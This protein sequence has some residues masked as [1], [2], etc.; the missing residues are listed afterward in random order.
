M[1]RRDLEVYRLQSLEL[2]RHRRG[3]GSVE[4]GCSWAGSA[5]SRLSRVKLQPVAEQMKRFIGLNNT[6]SVSSEPSSRRLRVY[7]RA[8]SRRRESRFS[9]RR[10]HGEEGLAN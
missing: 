2:A 9:F 7:S 3:G 5:P 8:R 1:D 4:R 10:R 6:V